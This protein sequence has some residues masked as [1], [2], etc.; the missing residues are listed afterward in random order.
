MHDTPFFSIEL[1]PNRPLTRRGFHAVL[2]IAAAGFAF[3][4][5]PLIGTPV[6]LALLPFVAVPLFGLWWF[7]RR[8]YADG[9]LVEYLAIWPDAIRVERHEADGRVLSWDGNPY[10]VR[11]SLRKDGPVEN[12]L[13]LRNSEREIELGAFLSPDERVALHDQLADA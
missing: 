9:R 1:W 11:L 10:W 4:L 12:Y 2:G 13:T 8:S 3:P 6:G 5:I 7:I